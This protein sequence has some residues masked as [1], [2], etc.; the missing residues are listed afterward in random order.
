MVA[1]TVCETARRWLGSRD[2]AAILTE[3]HLF[4]LVLLPSCLI[5]QIPI[6]QQA[7]KEIDAA[8][9]GAWA[10]TLEYR[11]YSE[12][13]TS[14][15]RV[16]LPTW[17]SVSNAGDNLLFEYVYD[18]GPSKTVKESSLVHIDMVSAVYTTTDSTGKLH[19][20]KIAGS[21]QL[22]SGRGV[23]TL[24]GVGAENGKPVGVRTTLRIGRNILEVM[25]ETA[26]T[27]QAFT[28]RHSYTMVRTAAP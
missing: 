26:S 5:E 17:L 1:F 14:N 7:A 3:V 27:G 28:F 20:Y 6:A 10:G 8:L 2:R 16:K 15:K 13:P 4:L 23:L 11:D 21:D 9:V 24:T 18:D 19:T 25:R 12:P 22:R